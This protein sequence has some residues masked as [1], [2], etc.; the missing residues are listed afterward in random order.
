[1]SQRLLE[2]GTPRHDLNVDVHRVSDQE[3]DIGSSYPYHNNYG[4][5]LRRSELDVSLTVLEV[6]LFTRRLYAL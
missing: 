6:E 5:E 3:L 4:R 2:T 1:M